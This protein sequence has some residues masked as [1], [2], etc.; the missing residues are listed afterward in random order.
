MILLAYFCTFSFVE[1]QPLCSNICKI[2]FLPDDWCELRAARTS[3]S[4]CTGAGPAGLLSLLSWGG[5][6]P[7]PSPWHWSPG[8]DPQERCKSISERQAWEL[9]LTALLGSR[10]RDAS[11]L[12]S[13]TARYCFSISNCI[14]ALSVC[15]DLLLLPLPVSSYASQGP[16]AL[17]SQSI[18][19]H[20]H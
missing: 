16:A 1:Q 9:K 11:V 18:I 2:P 7:K 8:P 3:P 6:V 13:F 10:I 20:R 15:R 4:D 17:L 19:D 14:S 5:T 12:R